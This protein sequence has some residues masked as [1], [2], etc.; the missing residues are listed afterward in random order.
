MEIPD[1]ITYNKYRYYKVRAHLS[2]VL[3]LRGLGDMVHEV[4]LTVGRL[5]HLPT[6]GQVVCDVIALLSK[7]LQ[8]LMGLK[9]RKQPL[10]KVTSRVVCDVIALLSK[11]L[12][13]KSDNLYSFLPSLPNCR[14]ILYVC[15][16]NIGYA[17]N[18]SMHQ[19]VLS[20]LCKFL[21]F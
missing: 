10:A 18:Q 4:D 16:Y 11:M 19:N 5:G 15:G 9:Q 7:V 3:P 14:S 20:L 8:L 6:W 1:Q 2:G 13:S 21:T 17:I 12:H